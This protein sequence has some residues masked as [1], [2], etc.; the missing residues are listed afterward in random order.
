MNDGNEWV[1]RW[2]ERKKTKVKVKGYEVKNKERKISRQKGKAKEEGE[3]T[4]VFIRR[5]KIYR[6]KLVTGRDLEVE[7]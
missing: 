4:T 2:T 1:K 3:E 6:E 7:I 5:G